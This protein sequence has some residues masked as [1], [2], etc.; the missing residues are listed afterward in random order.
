MVR[1]LKELFLKK[2]I[3]K[4]AQSVPSELDELAYE[5]LRLVFGGRSA[6]SSA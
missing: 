5:D 1:V 6:E 3:A 4:R 2:A